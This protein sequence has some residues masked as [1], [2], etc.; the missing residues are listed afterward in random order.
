M[1]AVLQVSMPKTIPNKLINNAYKKVLTFTTRKEKSIRE[2]PERLKAERVV[3][4]TTNLKINF[5]YR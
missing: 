4:H 5:I 1:V 3:S 2:P